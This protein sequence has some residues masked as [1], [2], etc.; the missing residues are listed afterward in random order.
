MLPVCKETILQVPVSKSQCYG[1][2]QLQI[3]SVGL[4]HRVIISVDFIPYAPQILH[5]VLAP[6]SVLT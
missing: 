5:D 1:Y 6:L 2:G 4:F 3:L